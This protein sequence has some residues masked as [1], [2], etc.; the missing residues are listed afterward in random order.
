M[1]FPGRSQ[2]D[3]QYAGVVRGENLT[4]ANEAHR[5]QNRPPR[6]PTSSRQLGTGSWNRYR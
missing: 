1:K 2:L 6:T 3:D 5:L 4:E